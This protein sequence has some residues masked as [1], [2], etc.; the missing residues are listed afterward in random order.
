M[1]RQ[2]L[3]RSAALSFAGQQQSY[4]GY[5]R[6]SYGMPTLA[7]G[8]T[9]AT[10]YA[11]HS[12]VNEYTLMQ[13]ALAE[14]STADRIRGNYENKIRFY[15]PPEKI[16]EV[17]ATKQREDGTLTM[18]YADFIRALVPYN[19]EAIK[20]NGQIEQ[21]LDWYGDE[22]KSLLKLAD[23]DGSQEIDFCEFLLFVA[24]LQIP[25]TTLARLFFGKYDNGKM[26]AE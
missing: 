7:F 2:M 25:E 13:P 22:I 11:Y 16:Y 19:H 20:N 6:W 21:Y 24:I 18:T 12:F 1:L 8:G 14:A 23:P 4:S 3:R 26:D 5:S 15:S 9:L 17:F 10:A